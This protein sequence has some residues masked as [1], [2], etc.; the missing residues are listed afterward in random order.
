MTDKPYQG[1]RGGRYVRA[2]RDE[3]PRRVEE[4]TVSRGKP[5]VQDDKGDVTTSTETASDA[6]ETA[7]KPARKRS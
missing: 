5:P 1:R 7:G 6:K 4:T 3:E 2:S